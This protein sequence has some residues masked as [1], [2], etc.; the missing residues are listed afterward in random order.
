[1]ASPTMISWVLTNSIA[2]NSMNTRD[3]NALYFLS[4]TKEIYRGTT[5]YSNSVVTYNSNSGLPTSGIAI[6]KLYINTDT[7]EG[8]MHDGTEW[9]NVIKPVSNILNDA[10]DYDDHIV[11]GIAVKAWVTNKIEE[12]ITS[13]A[14][15]AI[16]TKLGNTITVKGPGI[17]SY[18]NGSVISEDDDVWT[19]LRNMLET[20]IP[21]TYTAPTMSIN[22][23]NVSVEAGTAIQPTISSVFTQNDAGGVVRYL[24]TR[25]I[26]SDTVTLV[27]ST[28]ISSYI[29]TSINVED[30]D[31]F[32]TATIYYAAGPIKNDNLGKPDTNGSI[33]SGYLTITRRYSSYRKAFYGSENGPLVPCVTPAEIRALPLQ[34]TGAAPTGNNAITIQCT[35]G[36]TRVSIAY[37]ADLPDITRIKSVQLGDMNILAVFNKTI[38]PIGSLTGNSVIDYK[39]YTYIP[40][41]PFPAS[42]VYIVNFDN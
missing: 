10:T 3:D 29:D 21:P 11:T 18:S 14:V 6:N 20:R 13:G 24:L 16:N 22:L 36:D 33:P 5:S 28:V 27:D 15:K 2:F 32:Y 38:I 7:Y 41:I 4:D 40:D 17:G 30:A 31:V 37:P 26:G 9:V 25:T 1:M 35:E 23:S 12:I 42:D 19:V 8:Y 34:S 39:L